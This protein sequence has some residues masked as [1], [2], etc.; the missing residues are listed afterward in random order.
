MSSPALISAAQAH[1]DRLALVAPEG[2]FTYADLVQSATRVAAALL[3][4][5]RDLAEERVAFLVPPGERYVALQWGIWSAGGVSVP[6]CTSHPRGEL[7]HVV[8]DSGASVLIASDEFRERLA[9]VGRDLG[10]EVVRA[11]TLL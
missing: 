9:P 11:E 7:E 8:T 2:T 6:L 10:L 4:D 5:R 3:G 1:G